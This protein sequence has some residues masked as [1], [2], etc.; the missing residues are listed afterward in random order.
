MIEG[1]DDRSR[2]Q[3]C[4]RRAARV[5]LRRF[6][7]AG[8]VPGGA[9]QGQVPQNQQLQCFVPDRYTGAEI[10]HLFHER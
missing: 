2:S 5:R 7:T 6:R 10:E 1:T 3:D 8:H 9:A 4:F